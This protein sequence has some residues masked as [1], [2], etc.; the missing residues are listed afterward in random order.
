MPVHPG[1]TRRTFMR[2]VIGASVLGAFPFVGIMPAEAGVASVLN[3]LF[4]SHPLFAA[5]EVL[6]LGLGYVSGQSSQGKLADMA[7]QITSIS[8]RQDELLSALASLRIVMREEVRRAFL[9]ND[10]REMKAMAQSFELSLEDTDASRRATLGAM[11]NDINRAT[12]KMGGSGLAAVPA[13]LSA[14]AL[15]NGVHHVLGSQTAVVARFN[16][17]HANVLRSLLN[18]TGDESLVHLIETTPSA[19]Q[20]GLGPL[21]QLGAEHPVARVARIYDWGGFRPT[22]DTYVMGLRYLGIRNRRPQFEWWSGPATPGLR[23]DSRYATDDIGQ[24][25]VRDIELYY[26]NTAGQDYLAIPG[27]APSASREGNAPRRMK[28]DASG[29][30]DFTGDDANNA[31]MMR[32]MG[33]LGDYYTRLY[34]VSLPPDF[35]DQGTVPSDIT[36]QTVARA[37]HH[38]GL[39]SLLML[40]LDGASRLRDA[41]RNH[42][43]LAAPPPPVLPASP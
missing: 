12:F 16:D 25:R 43:Q 19:A 14:I 8:E 6:E 35:S 4:L 37:E 21:Y 32:K 28:I 9:D 36:A 34:R 33:E 20:G 1:T 38:E 2:G 30:A 5:V 40:G 29:F 18:G 11:V 41:A 15:Q 3:Y 7:K 24:Q 31:I 10:I 23:N 26:A 39:R 17:M 13:Y 42:P 22:A 27:G